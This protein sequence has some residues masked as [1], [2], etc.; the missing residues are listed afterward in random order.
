MVHVVARK[1]GGKAGLLHSSALSLD[2]QPLSLVLVH[3]SLLSPSFPL[4]PW[5]LSR[6]GKKHTEA[7]AH[8]RKAVLT[9]DWLL[10][11]S[12]AQPLETMG[13]YPY[14]R[15]SSVCSTLVV[16]P[17]HQRYCRHIVRWEIVLSSSWLYSVLLF[18]R[19]FSELLE[20]FG[21]QSNTGSARSSPILHGGGE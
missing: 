14:A 17:C 2:R 9:W 16:S 18:R 13:L 1:P 11:L 20:K 12:L 21:S 4:S 5:T 3:M 8:H 10:T 15:E 7:P 19:E 6:A